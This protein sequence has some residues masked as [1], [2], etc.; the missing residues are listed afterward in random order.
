M[1]ILKK[2]LRYLGILLII[3]L[4]GII[5]Y[6]YWM[7][8]IPSDTS[9][10]KSINNENHSFTLLRNSY[11]GITYR[12]VVSENFDDEK[13]TI[14]LV[15]GSI[16]SITSFKEY[17]YSLSDSEFNLL[18]LDR[19]NY[20]ND[21]NENYE[22]SISFEALLVNNLSEQYWSTQENIILGYSYGGPI[23]LFAHALRPHDSVI[24]VSPAIDPDNEVVPPPIYFYKWSLTRPLVP[25]VWVEA[26][27]EKLGHVEDLKQ[28]I[29]LWKSIQGNI[30]HIHGNNDPIVPYENVQFLQSRIPENSYTHILIDEGGH[31]ILW[32]EYK[33][34]LEL[35][36]EQLA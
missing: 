33:K 12:Y 14:I 24:L 4:V 32:S 2:I 1:K 20:G 5:S 10:L 19:P 7:S 17:T 11:E 31:G 6:F 26:S 30:I 16:G 36:K 22:Q 21:F 29:D 15:H 8:Q 27:K 35:I 3:V 28:Y 13:P 23:A 18:I 34:I 25:K 9:L